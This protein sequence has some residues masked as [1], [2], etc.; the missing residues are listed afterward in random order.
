MNADAIRAFRCEAPVP[1]TFTFD[2]PDYSGRVLRVIRR[3][4]YVD[5]SG[6]TYCSH[7]RESDDM[8][9]GFVGGF[10]MGSMF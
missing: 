4:S 5:R 8:G 6:P 9:M 1:V 10:M 7:S 3:T 2:I